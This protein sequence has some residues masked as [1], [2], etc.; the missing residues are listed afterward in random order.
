VRR[1]KRAIALQSAAKVMRQ[2]NIDSDEDLL[3]YCEADQPSAH[4]RLLACDAL[5]A[6]MGRA[7]IPFLLRLAANPD[8]SVAD[9]GFHG[10]RCLGTRRATRLYLR[11]IRASADNHWRQGAI[12]ALRF[13]GD[14]RAEPGLAHVLHTDQC[15]ETRALAAEAL[16]YVHRGKRSVRVLLQALPDPSPNVRWWI[17]S[18]LGGIPRL[19]ARTLGIIRC[20]LSDHAVVRGFA[21][22]ESSTVA[23]AAQDALNRQGR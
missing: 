9:A 18:T 17:L 11:R 21:D 8:P 3:K 10:L 13:L 23:D 6:R 22:R 5:A 15:S 20:Y 1:R 12:D 19:D 4:D 14:R 7:A 2:L 16:W